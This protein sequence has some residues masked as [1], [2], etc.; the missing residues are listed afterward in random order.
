[1]NIKFR[2][3]QLNADKMWDLILIYIH[4]I[5]DY[6]YKILAFNLLVKSI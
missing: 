5:P 2:N 4:R 3:K 1:M 6:A